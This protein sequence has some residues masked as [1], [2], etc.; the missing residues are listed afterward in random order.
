[1]AGGTLDR[2]GAGIRRELSTPVTRKRNQQL[3][4]TRDSGIGTG[5]TCG[6]GLTGVPGMQEAH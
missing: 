3:P 1:M 4:D 2:Q 6:P 5:D